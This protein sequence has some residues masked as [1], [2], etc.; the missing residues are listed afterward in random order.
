MFLLTPISTDY[1]VQSADW[2]LDRGEV[3]ISAGCD[4]IMCEEIL[5]TFYQKL[6]QVFAI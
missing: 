4:S 6:Q 1:I 5:K 3:A 2:I